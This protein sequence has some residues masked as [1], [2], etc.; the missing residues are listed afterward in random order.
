MGLPA[1]NLSREAIA[2]S[3]VIERILGPGPHRYRVLPPY[4]TSLGDSAV[5]ITLE[6]ALEYALEYTREYA[7]QCDHGYILF[8]HDTVPGVYSLEPWGDA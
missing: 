2:Q 6:S 3:V 1:F 7:D 5:A 8:A 4:A